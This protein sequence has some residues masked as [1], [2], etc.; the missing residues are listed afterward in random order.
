[1]TTQTLDRSLT[2]VFNMT[3]DYCSN[4]TTGNIDTNQRLR[5]INRAIEDVHRRLGLTCDEQIFNFVYSQNNMFTT[6]P[7]DF[8]EP[9][10]LY[11]VNNAFNQG[12]Q[13][14]WTW[15]KYTRLLQASGIGSGLGWGLGKPLSQYGQKLFSS[16]NINGSKQLI[17]LGS[18]ILQGGIVNPYNTTALTTAVGDATTLAVDNNV[19][20]NGGGSLSFTI[21]PALGYGY[22]GILTT[23]FGVMNVQYAL[24]NNGLYSI[25][26]WLPT[27]NIS[28]I[29]LILT[30]SVGNYYT[31]T[32]TAQNNGTPFVNSTLNNLWNTTS[33][34][35]SLVGITG[36]PNSQQITS[37]QVNFVE[38]A[39]FGGSAIPFFRIDNF[40]LNYP[41]NM[42]LIYYTQFKG[43][44]STGVTNKFYLDQLTDL[45]T[46]MQF[47]PD[48]L[49][50]VALRAAYI[51][52]PQ[53]SADK[54]FMTQY[55]KDY[56]EQMSDLGKIYP[57]KRC[58]NLGSTM[59]RRP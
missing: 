47:F 52:M 45:P 1:M 21:N 27:T 34:Q 38:G 14:G 50:M 46:F 11:Y 24:Q 58:V 26:S 17:Q 41:D 48:F 15:D 59:L 29:N 40:V 4:Y 9:I 42:N 30:S 32:A 5:A 7:V 22:G 37:Y 10:L 57:R 54:D 3:N 19:Y 23:G 31:F 33:Y 12:G 2:P 20:T 56:D 28:A 35:W 51:L 43:T 13:S 36:S 16:T 8:D 55:K 18:N 6:L 44:D 39:S 49:N 53:L 25:S